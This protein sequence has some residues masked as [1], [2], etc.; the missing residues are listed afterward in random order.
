MQL[1][2]REVLVAVTIDF[3]DDLPGDAVERAAAELTLAVEAAHPEIT[4]LF[5]RP[6]RLPRPA[7]AL[8]A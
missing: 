5:M 2:P 4:R 7:V 3:Q 6:R 8:S 1:G